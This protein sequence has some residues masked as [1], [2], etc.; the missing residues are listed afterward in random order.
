MPS[1]TYTLIKEPNSPELVRL[2]EKIARALVIGF[3]IE[4]TSLSPYDGEIR[5][6]Q[7]NT[8]GEVYVVDLFLTGGLGPVEQAMR[9]T[10]AIW[11]I[12]QAKFEQKWC[13]Y[14]FKIE[15][16]PLFD[17]WRADNLITNGKD[18]VKHDLYALYDRY[19]GVKPEAPD[20]ATLPWSGPLSIAHYDYA[21]ED[22]VYL[23][24]LRL[25]QKPLLTENGLNS[26]ALIE[27][28]VVMA[29]AETELNGFRLDPDMWRTLAKENEA[30]AA[31]LHKQ[32]IHE[33]PSPTNQMTLAGF[34]PT[35]NLDSPA[36]ILT[37]LRKLGLKQRVKNEETG[38]Y[39]T[40]PL[41][42][43]KEMT[44]AGFAAK[45]PIVDK[46]ISYRGFS[47]YGS[48][49]GEEFLENVRA[50]TGRIHSEY[51][52]FTGAGRYSNGKPN[53]QQIPRLPQFRACFR[54]VEGRKLV[55]ADYS[56]IEM[57][58]VAEIAQDKE[59]IRIFNAREDAHRVTAA[60]MLEKSASEITK[61]ERQMAKPVNFGF[62]LSAGTAVVTTS[63]LKSIEE[64]VKGEKVLTHKKRWRTV[65]DTQALVTSRTLRIT[66]RTGKIVESTPDHMW[67]VTFPAANGREGAQG[68]VRSEDLKV[69]QYLVFHDT[70][71]ST[72]TRVIPPDTAKMLGWFLSE[73]SWSKTGG[74]Q[75]A[76]SNTANPAITKNMREVLG[77]LH[78]SERHDGEMSRFFLPAS[79]TGEVGALFDCD[80]KAKAADKNLPKDVHHWSAESTRNLLAGLWDGD[81]CISVVGR[82][83]SITYCSKSRGLLRGISSLLDTLGINTTIY[84]YG[85]NTG[86]IRVVGT[87]SIERFLA[88][89]PTSKREKVTYAPKKRFS[90]GEAI[91]S[92]DIVDQPQMVYDLTVAEDHSFVAN[93]LVTHNCFG[94]MPS[95]L[96]LYAQAN[97]GVVMSEA[98]ATK[99]RK[100][101]FELYED[102]AR[103][104]IRAQRDG[105]RL[106]MSRTIG[107][108]LRYLGPDAYNEFYNTPVQGTGADGLKRSLRIVN[109]AL[110]KL[111]G[112]ARIVHHVHDE[113]IT[114]V[115]DDPELEAAVKKIL[116]DGMVE[117]MSCFLRSVPV[118]VEP[119]SG[120]SWA[121]AK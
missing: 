65:T 100:R 105:Q 47:K 10:K 59:L 6:M 79:R 73:G 115:D 99:F 51:F 92:I 56:A 108:R 19:L 53:I 37:S 119:S 116:H 18:G 38:T 14:K 33:L 35:F 98:Q 54:P 120:A 96:V 36:Q 64:I 5:L 67:L 95:K 46:F 31:L 121:E 60:A 117:G 20:M 57:R 97:Y 45:Y 39:E 4:T 114:E 58:I 72:G 71:W 84:D 55:L 86:S 43:T 88:Q 15:F 29:E 7:F 110:R 118:E 77:R 26:T 102:V 104:H 107:G 27:F 44:L 80:L 42:D 78:F 34:D 111:N 22:V 24:R 90:C 62:C 112:R 70:A 17:T 69:G 63:G 41:Q 74:F 81:G 52:P 16:W 11:V 28:G 113:I 85:L 61:S 76:Q 82:K 3:D 32:L 83:V 89:I 94:M 109:A 93:G 75:I 66:T 68:W 87:E 12:Q 13:W 49:F 40:V 9:D 2:A 1:Y 48:S 101:Y 25:A 30:Q 106:R 23:P 91:A 21:A 103:W 50:S 8:D